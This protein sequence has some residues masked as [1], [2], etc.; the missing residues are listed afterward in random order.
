MILKCFK[1]QL[2]TMLSHTNLVHM[3][4]ESI[5]IV[6]V[7][8]IVFVIVVDGKR[9]PRFAFHGCFPRFLDG[10]KN[11]FHGFCTVFPPVVR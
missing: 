10:N 4:N 11:V 8:V 1:L 9:F 5:V 2:I 3:Y 6:V 7:V